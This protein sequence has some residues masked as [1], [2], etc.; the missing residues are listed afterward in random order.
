MSAAPLDAALAR[1]VGQEDPPPLAN[2][3]RRLEPWAPSLRGRPIDLVHPRAEDIDF[4]EM[5]DVL[6]NINRYGG[7]A[8][9]RITVA[10]HT[11]IAVKAARQRNASPTLQAYVALHDGH[12]WVLGD[13]T[14]PVTLAQAACANEMFGPT[15]RDHEIGAREELKRRH[16]HAIWQAAGLPPPSNEQRAFI[17][18]CDIVAL[19][20]EKRDFLLP[21]SRAWSVDLK[22]YPPLPRCEKP[23]EPGD[24][25]DAL[26]RLFRTLLPSLRD[27]TGRG[28]R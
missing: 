4:R 27:G 18:A 2:R 21:C 5:A 22:P 11:L 15:A 10:H 25:A 24:A 14:T 28:G 6:A 9:R 3:P 13:Q 26:W 1:T 19:H 16:D 20:T 17:T 7:N 12:E 8:F 23:M